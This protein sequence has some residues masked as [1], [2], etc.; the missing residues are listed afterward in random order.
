VEILILVVW[1]VCGV[2]AAA[3]A[4]DKGRSGC[5]G[6]LLGLLLGPIGLAIVL[7]MGKQARDAT[8][9][10]RPCPACREPVEPA[11]TICPHC[12]TV[13]SD[14]QVSEALEEQKALQKLATQN[15]LLGAAVGV[16]VLLGVA[17]LL[18]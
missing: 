7:L 1:G 5:G 6:L 11:A 17:A 10:K 8:A 2:I 9:G 13:F 4:S 12:R 3:V 18:V 16:L 14:E 15:Q